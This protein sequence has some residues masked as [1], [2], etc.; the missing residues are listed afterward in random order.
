[1]TRL[2]QSDLYA[3]LGFI[4]EIDGVK[5]QAIFPDRL[6]SSL[7]KLI[8]SDTICYDEM[9]ADGAKLARSHFPVDAVPEDAE[10]ACDRLVHQHPMVSHYFLTR[11][12][13]ALTASD[14]VSRRD[15]KRLELY[16]DCYHR[17]GWE[18][19]LAVLVPSARSLIRA[20]MF[21][22]QR[23]DYSDRDRMVAELIRPHIAQAQLAAQT[24]SLVHGM[25]T[26]VERAAEAHHLT[27]RE[28]E[29]LDLVAE[30]LTNREIAD[31]LFVSDRTVH[32]HV[33]NLF[34]KLG[35][36]TRMAAARALSPSPG[37]GRPDTR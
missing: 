14:F 35:V 10:A 27:R 12:S 25:V 19:Q 33:E 16:Q 7:A 13:R 9:S 26:S 15:F 5:E 20:L 34:R 1:M 2:S 30:G 6:L 29:V 8:P 4:Q 24:R 31:A 28:R 22:R 21:N 37:G 3:V 18:Y 17:I 36:H 32:K 23:R 11:D